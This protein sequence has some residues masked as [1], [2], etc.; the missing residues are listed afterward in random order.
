MS[1]N[2]HNANAKSKVRSKFYQKPKTQ[3]DDVGPVPDL[4]ITGM[5]VAAKANV[6]DTTNL[7][8]RR[9]DYDKKIKDTINTNYDHEIKTKED[10][11]KKLQE[12]IQNLN[13]LVK[14][15]DLA[16][17][18]QPSMEIVEEE[19][20][21]TFEFE[22]VDANSIEGD[23]SILIV[24]KS[25]EFEL[26]SDEEDE[27]DQVNQRDSYTNSKHKKSKLRFDSGS[28]NKHNSE[29]TTADKSRVD[30]HAITNNSEHLKLHMNSTL[31]N[32]SDNSIHMKTSNS[33]CDLDDKSKSNSNQGKKDN[34]LDTQQVNRMI[35][36]F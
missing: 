30:F 4:S 22:I 23:K 9:F 26:S 7:T 18:N 34:K 25:R 36:D 28:H 17:I 21:Q 3:R 35:Q 27:F 15:T 29:M 6:K 32:L 20:E 8:S 19:A 10:E 31:G 13:K 14:Q 5:K 33:I 2:I 12:D 24:D 1:T 16:L 11:L